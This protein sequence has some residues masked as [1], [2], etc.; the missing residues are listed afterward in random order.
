MKSQSVVSVNPMTSLVQ[1][2]VA[3]QS[4]CDAIDNGLELTEAVKTY[5]TEA[6]LAQSQGVDEFLDFRSSVKGKLESL[7]DI[8]RIATE[9]IKRLE[10]LLEKA[11]AQAVELLEAAPDLPFSGSQ[12]KLSAAKNPP[13]VE[14]LFP[15]SSASL[16]N[17]V[18]ESYIDTLG[19]EER[20]YKVKAF[21]VLDLKEISDA[22]KGGEEL[23]WVKLKQKKRLNPKLKD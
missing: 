6:K 4:I 8:K 13:S 19:I 17:I 11:D 12:L 16:S 1:A 20:F 3:L 23:M 14:V 2:S 7:K 22:L 9:R 21:L 5:F 18:E 15:T 10:E